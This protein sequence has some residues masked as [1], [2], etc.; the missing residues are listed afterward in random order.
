MFVLTSL[1]GVPSH[2][3]VFQT[4]DLRL[5][6]TADGRVQS[7]TS[8]PDGTQYVATAGPVAVAYRGGRSVCTAQGPFAA[9]V[10]R[11]VYEGG[12]RLEATRA[13]F[14]GDRLSVGFG[15]GLCATCRVRTTDHYLAFELLGVEGGPVDRV[16]FLQLAVR[17]LPY[18]GQWIGTTYDDRFGIGLCGGNPQTNIETVPRDE[19]VHLTAAAETS[20]GLAGAT[21]VLFGCE[22]PKTTFLGRMAEVERAFDMPAGATSRRAPA[23]RLSYLW[24]SRPTPDNIQ[25][26]IAFAQRGGLRTIL[27]SYTAFSTAP[28]HF[29]W[30]ERYRN[31]MADLRR[32][33]DAIRR[34][35]L[36]LGLH[37]HYSKVGKKDAYVTPVPDDRLHLVRNFTLAGPITANAGVLPVVEDPAGCTLDA[38]RRLLKLGKELVEY[39]AYSRQKPFQFTGC[40][41]GSLGTRAAA[42]PAAA[43]F[44]LLDVDTWPAFIRIDQNTDLQDEIAQRIAEIYR[45]AGP[46]ELVYF[47]G[48]EDV[49]EPFWY[50]AAAAQY[51][52]F[53][54][55]EPPP[56]VCEAAHYTH[57]SWHFISRSNA[58]DVVA[59]PEGMKDFCRLM[60]C[61]TA[62]ARAMDFSRIDFGWLGRFGRSREGCA[63]P[64]VYEY[65]ASRGA[66]WDCPLSLHATQED[67]RANP[68][69][70]DC[71]A[72]I[73]TWE[74]ARL[75]N[76][77]SDAQRR[78]L[79]NV[80][81]ADARYVPCFEQR[82]IFENLR[83]NRNLSDSQ[84]RI[85]ADRREHHLLVD[86]QGRCELVEVTEVPDVAGGA[87]KAFLFR[88]AAEPAD[89]Y[90]LAWAVADSVRLSIP[91][92]NVTAM[93]P[94]GVR[95][96][97]RVEEDACEIEI[98]PR[99]YL[100]FK[101]TPPETTQRMLQRSVRCWRMTLRD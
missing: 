42:H 32:V 1:C 55:L 11:W 19:Q 47:D 60:P 88:R 18:L 56:S 75:G 10:G 16:E 9:V 85:L 95:Q 67:L 38:G 80:A 14:R 77:L 73:K 99:T 84:R 17:R 5:E 29:A 2:A 79:C 94:L 82:G 64:D 74:D 7:L 39:E 21:A 54:R 61:P 35:G 46:F 62:A 78:I 36:H 12:Q 101:N 81:P 43:E 37:I 31:G 93:R 89:T 40:R 68:R 76:Q 44:G 86:E 66:A 83:Q 33:T 72:T 58:Y 41:R 20:V 57:F 97:C 65:I 69:A 23:Q 52:V 26:Y 91:T 6:I 87:V 98:G 15:D 59:P 71:L 50:H 45:Q 49:H 3:A 13:E 27:I 24:A 51:R 90:V 28:G 96:P 100:L 70:D 63:G 48:A 25:D 34:A 22:Q 30:N 53:R 4:R 8:R 92:N